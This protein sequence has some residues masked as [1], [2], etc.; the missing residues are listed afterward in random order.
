MSSAQQK[1]IGVGMT[2]EKQIT[3][4]TRSDRPTPSCAGFQYKYKRI[5]KM[6][7]KQRKKGKKISRVTLV[8]IKAYAMK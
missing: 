3:M 4:E 6:H 8:G 2:V 1:K 5:K 7:E